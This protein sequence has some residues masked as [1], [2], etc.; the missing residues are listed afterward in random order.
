MPPRVALAWWA[1]AEDSG[2]S[3]SR[4]ALHRFSTAAWLTRLR[5]K[6]AHIVFKDTKVANLQRELA[7]ARQALT[8]AGTAPEASYALRPSV[9][10]VGADPSQ[11]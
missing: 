6:D 4:A 9:A 1:T 10:P 8:K 5:M 11:V 3:S 2:G 7:L